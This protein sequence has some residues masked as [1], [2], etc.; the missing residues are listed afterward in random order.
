MLRQRL[1]CLLFCWVV[2][3]SPGTE[4][5]DTSGNRMWFEGATLIVGDGNAPIEDSAFLVE[6][7]TFRLVGRQGE[8]EP[9]EGAV[10]VDLSGKTV[11][12]ALIDA[13]QHIGLTDVQDWTNRTE[14]YTRE[15]LVEHL[16]RVDP[17]KNFGQ[18]SLD[19]VLEVLEVH[20]L[21]L[22]MDVPET[23]TENGVSA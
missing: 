10:R 6:G 17:T 8:V 11:I 13:H 7:S 14:N 9:P 16:Q 3:C 4:I 2:A 12:P 1:F 20:G 23:T 19:E 5:P 15:N 22:G 21:R 18:R